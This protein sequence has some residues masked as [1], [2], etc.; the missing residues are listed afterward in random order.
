MALKLLLVDGDATVPALMALVLEPLECEIRGFCDP[1]LAAAQ[2]EAE[3]FDAALIDLELAGMSGLEFAESVRASARNRSIPLVLMSDP[4][5]GEA[6]LRHEYAGADLG[7]HFYLAKP[8]TPERLYGIYYAL[9]RAI[10]REKRHFPRVPLRLPV[11]CRADGRE[12]ELYS[13]DLSQ[14]GMCLTA[15]SGDAVLPKT[16]ELEFFLPHTHE[17]VRCRAQVLRQGPAD[18][19]GVEF[20]GVPPE[21]EALL[22]RQIDESL[23][24]AAGA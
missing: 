15:A 5:Q 7:I 2:L 17:R 22:Q 6:A 9:R 11:A 24:A 4:G 20:F 13:L 18:A 23:R 1:R 3:S 16:L 8:F 10:G 12:Y 21:I 19:L 14:G